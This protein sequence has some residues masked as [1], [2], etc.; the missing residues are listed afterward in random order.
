MHTSSIHNNVL[1][2]LTL[3]ELIVARFVGTGDFSVRY[4]KDHTK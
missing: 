2:Y 1:C 3:I 4:S